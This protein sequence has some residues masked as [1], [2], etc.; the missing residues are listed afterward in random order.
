MEHEL[1]ILLTHGILHLLGYDH[2][3][4]DEETEMF[5]LQRTL[6]AEFETR[7]PL[8]QAGPLVQARLASLPGTPVIRTIDINES[9]VATWVLVGKYRTDAQ[10]LGTAMGT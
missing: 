2:A 7:I 8:E 5:G 1:R 3:G 10:L 6:V 9:P 4:P